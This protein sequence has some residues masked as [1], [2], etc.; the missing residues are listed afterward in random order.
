MAKEQE[1]NISP[2]GMLAVRKEMGE[3]M[4]AA[5]KP[6]KKSSKVDAPKTKRKPVLMSSDSKAASPL[7][8]TKKPMI[9]I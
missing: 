3:K 8:L 1:M 4:V 6:T 5:K 9:K 7:P 2:T